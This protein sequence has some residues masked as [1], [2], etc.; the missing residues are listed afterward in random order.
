MNSKCK[1]IDK[2]NNFLST[3][4]KPDPKGF[5][6]KIWLGRPDTLDACLMQNEKKEMEHSTQRVNRRSCPTE[7]KLP[8]L[9]LP[10]HPSSEH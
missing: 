4:L 6:I 2:K 3:A 10:T 5:H 7:L 9:E 8:I 1:T